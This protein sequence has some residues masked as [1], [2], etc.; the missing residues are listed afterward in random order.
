MPQRDNATMSMRS[1]IT[2]TRKIR[3]AALQRA[4][5][6]R[7]NAQQYAMQQCNAQQ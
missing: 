2:A 7:C 5:M 1:M 6:Q 3:C 4:T